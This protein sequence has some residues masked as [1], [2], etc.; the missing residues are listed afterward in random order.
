MN[1]LC[2]IS[3][4]TNMIHCFVKKKLASS[5]G[6]PQENDTNFRF[7]IHPQGIINQMYDI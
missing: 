2:L 1:I 5:F 7:A 3:Y 6:A 4:L